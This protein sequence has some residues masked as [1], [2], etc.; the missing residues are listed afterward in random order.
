MLND[1]ET[2]AETAPGGWTPAQIKR[3][4]LAIAVMSV[5]L[6]AGFILLFVGIYLQS[7]K[8]AKEPEA[9]PLTPPVGVYGTLPLPVRPGTELTQILT[10]QGR[11][12]LHLRRQ[13]GSEIAIL[14]LSTG[15][16]IQRIRLVPQE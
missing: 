4:K 9:S 16:E 3:L 8:L 2:E 13:G 1:T 11:L 5:M 7:Q 14:E 15:R 6:V 12:I 10:D